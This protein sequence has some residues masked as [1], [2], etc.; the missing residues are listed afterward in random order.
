MTETVAAQVHVLTP[1][2]WRWRHWGTDG[3]GWHH[4]GGDTRKKFHFWGRI[5]KE[6]WANDVGKRREWKWW[7]D[8]S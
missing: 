2:C 8:S 3:P 7:P 1:T 4:P 6:H 5:Y